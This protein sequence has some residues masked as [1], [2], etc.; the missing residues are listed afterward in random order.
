MAVPKKRQSKSRRNR[1]RA[2]HDRVAPPTVVE[3]PNCSEPTPPHQVCPACGYY[4]GE[5]VIAVAEE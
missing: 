1:R 2:Q 5:Q 4:K 3:C